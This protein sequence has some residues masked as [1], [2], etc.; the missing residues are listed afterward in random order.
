MDVA[1]FAKS[2]KG[3]NVVSYE[4]GKNFPS[5]SLIKIFIALCLGNEIEKGRLSL[6]DT[7]EFDISDENSVA[8]AGALKFLE[9]GH[10]FSMNELMR[11]MLAFSDNCATNMLIDY[12][13]LEKIQDFLTDKYP[14]TRLNRKMMQI[15]KSADKDN[16]STAKEVAEALEEI[17][18]RAQAGEAYYV[19]ILDAL[20]KQECFNSLGL[21]IEGV[22][23]AHKTGTLVNLEHDAGIVFAE[24][25]SYIVVVLV[26]GLSNQRCREE[27]GKISLDV[28][29]EMEKAK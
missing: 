11:L 7:M 15:P 5:A 18:S 21:Y 6:M 12:I 28:F 1:Y 24:D 8:G 16:L 29:K 20:R 13:G 19:E 4:D 26:K 22:E 23:I 17:F 2:L 14:N 9:Q 25:N 10:D 27:I 3:E